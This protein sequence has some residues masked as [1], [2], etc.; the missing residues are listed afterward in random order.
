MHGG[1]SNNVFWPCH[2]K[3]VTI[4]KLMRLSKACHQTEHCHFQPFQMLKWKRNMH[5]F[6][7]AKPVR[8]NTCSLISTLP[9]HHSKWLDLLTES[10]S[11]VTFHMDSHT[12]H[13]FCFEFEKAQCFSGTIQSPF[14]CFQ[15]FF[16]ISQPRT[17]FCARI[18]RNI[19]FLLSLLRCVSCIASHA[20]ELHQ[21][22]QFLHCNLH[23]I[24]HPHNTTFAFPIINAF[25]ANLNSGWP[26]H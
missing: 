20:S 1:K 14:D 22:S 11:R 21:C 26:C 6:C 5:S 9:F 4:G 24:W 17:A 7:N 18:L 12:S 10:S 2:F 25:H 8:S 23:D 3:H 13:H 15:K 19:C 16:D